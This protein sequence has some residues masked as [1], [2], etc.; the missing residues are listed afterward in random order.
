MNLINEFDKYS[1]VMLERDK[2]QFYKKLSYR[3]S[4]LITNH[5]MKIGYNKRIL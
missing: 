5:L 2:K 3:F 1:S 4:I